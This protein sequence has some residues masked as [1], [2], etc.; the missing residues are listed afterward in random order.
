MNGSS[1]KITDGVAISSDGAFKPVVRMVIEGDEAEASIDLS[2]YEARRI[3]LDL[4]SA[5]VMSWSSVGI[6]AYAKEHGVDGDGI[7]GIIRAWVQAA[8]EDES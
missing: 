3:G 6:R 5:A 1:V 8:L 2:P 7:I 4:L